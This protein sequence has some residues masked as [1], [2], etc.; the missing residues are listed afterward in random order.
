MVHWDRGGSAPALSLGEPR[1]PLRRLIVVGVVFSLIV[2]A[3]VIG[4][5]IASSD[6]IALGDCVVTSPN[7]ATG[8]NIK[9]IACNSNPRSG[10]VIQKV[11]SVQN[12]ANGQC[13]LG[14]NTFQDDSAGK[15]YCLSGYSFDG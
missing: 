7:L 4:H 14:L 5:A 11:V 13:N 12:G 1:V 9:K 15:T 3:A 6:S 2:I 10:L 8:W